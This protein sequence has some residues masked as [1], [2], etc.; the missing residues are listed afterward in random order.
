MLQKQLEK[1][2]KDNGHCRV[3]VR[4]RGETIPF[5][6]I[7]VTTQR[8]LYKKHKNNKPARGIMSDDRINRL[9]NIGFE[10]IGWK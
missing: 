2:R 3:P 9:E 6:G 5:L 8:D 10:W 7:W 4:Y 1:F